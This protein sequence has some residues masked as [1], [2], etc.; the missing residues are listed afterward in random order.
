MK[1]PLLL[2]SIITTSSFLF[3]NTVENFLSPS[4]M[5]ALSDVDYKVIQLAPNVML[6]APLIK[7]MPELPR[8]CEVTSL[9]MLLQYAGVSVNK[10]TLAAEIQK[11]PTP[12]YVK[13]GKTYFGNPQVGF[14]GN[15]YTFSKPGYG[16]YSKPIAH[17]AEKYLPGKIVNLS[18]RSF[19][20]L[21]LSLTLGKPVWVVTNVTF[22]PLS[23]RY[24]QT[25]HHP[26]GSFTKITMKE[27]SVLLTGYDEKFVYFHDPLSG[28]K[29]EKAP[30][31]D[32]ISSWVQMG[33]HAISYLD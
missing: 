25:W 11:D 20:E 26:D 30:I 16:V 14:V 4:P 1:K 9:A 19:K 31:K 18:N 29:H 3:Y 17:L 21:Q 8:G 32:F 33:S 22:A 5:P 10:L 27:H 7:Q 13:D 24:F 12:R 28:K 2:V 6:D 15:M 23:E